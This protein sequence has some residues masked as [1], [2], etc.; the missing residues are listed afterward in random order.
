MLRWNFLE[1]EPLFCIL[2]GLIWFVRFMEVDNLEFGCLQFDVSK[3]PTIIHK[4]LGH[5]SPGE[6]QT[7]SE[8]IFYFFKWG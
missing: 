1:I 3:Y 2:L 4:V 6:K 5:Q 7:H 8:I